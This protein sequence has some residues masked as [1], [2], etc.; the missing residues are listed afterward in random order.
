MWWLLLVPIG[1][2]AAELVRK[3]E[4]P[5]DIPP[6]RTRRVTSAEVP[7]DVRARAVELL[8]QPLGYSEDFRGADGRLWRLVV[9]EHFRAHDSAEPGPKGRHKGVSALLHTSG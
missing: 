3:L 1:F 9:E 7:A 5:L 8:P 2:L 4:N 6:G